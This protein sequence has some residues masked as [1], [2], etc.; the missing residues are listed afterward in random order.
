MVT[1]APPSP[2]TQDPTVPT[3]TKDEPAKQTLKGLKLAVLLASITLV[4]F[5]A[6]IDTSIIGTV[7]ASRPL[8]ATNNLLM[9]IG[10][11][12]N[13]NRLPLPSRCWL[14]YWRIQPRIRHPSTP[15]R[16]IL[17]ALPNQGCVSMFRLCV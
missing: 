4:T 16:Q 17:Y 8:L 9:F 3:T 12:R 15:V 10:Y 7:R 6:L 14:V 5:L 13:N 11:T 1:R 2:T